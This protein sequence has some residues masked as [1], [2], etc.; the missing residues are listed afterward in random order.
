MEARQVVAPSTPNPSPARRDVEL[1]APVAA[2]RTHEHTA[3]DLEMASI[4]LYYAE[5]L[6]KEDIQR[7]AREALVTT[8]RTVAEIY[9]ETDAN[10]G[11]N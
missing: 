10:E 7:V 8:N 1:L 4:Y 5:E 11:A 9:T 6:E 3:L 2:A